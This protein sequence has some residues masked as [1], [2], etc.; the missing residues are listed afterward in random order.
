[1]RRNEIEVWG[2]K[3]PIINIQA[4]KVNED[5]KDD[6]DEYIIADL[7]L[8]ETIGDYCMDGNDYA[9]KIDEQI[10]F[11]AHKPLDSFKTEE[12][13]VEYLKKYC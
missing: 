5:I 10:Y 3:F 11:Y 6:D 1:M 9:N 4:N 13:L 2:E 7:S 8:W 12:E